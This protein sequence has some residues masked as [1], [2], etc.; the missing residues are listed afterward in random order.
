[1]SSSPPRAEAQVLRR[2]RLR[3]ALWSGSTTLIV[4]L[5]LG[6]IVYAFVAQQLARDSEEQLRARATLIAELKDPTI[7]PA[8]AS[9]LGLVAAAEKAGVLFGGPL[10]GTI[11]ITAEMPD[12]AANDLSRKTGASDKTGLQ[13]AGTPTAVELAAKQPS[14][15]LKKRI[16]DAAVDSGSTDG[17]DL[18]LKDIDGVPTRILSVDAG[19]PE[20]P[21]VVHVIADRTIELRTLSNLAL[22]MLI[23]GFLVVVAATAAGW[24]YSGRALVPIR[25]SLRRQREFAADASHELRTPL[26]VLR[27]ELELL[28]RHPGEPA[29]PELLAD[30]TAETERMARLVDELLL[31]ARTDADQAPLDRRPTDLAEAAFDAAEALTGEA[32]QRSVR[33]EVD[34]SPAPLSGDPDRLRQLAAI[35]VD[36]AIKHGRAGGHVWVR[37]R[38]DEADARLEVADDGAGIA[39]EDRERIFLRFWRGCD[40]RAPGSGLGLPIARWIVD[41]HDGR[42]HVAERP[43][44]GT[45]IVV[46]LP[47]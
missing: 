12:S 6:V 34:A 11:A 42:I 35:L 3:L 30:A 19:T 23:G 21:F 18:T 27:N 24:V 20:E 9:T 14:L 37:V 44:G 15:T 40:T 29:D 16:A 28:A 39:P 26:T 33:V 31:L 2:T 46:T 43:E 47:R 4:L 1:M 38:S 45:R 8:D 25:A 5:I 7:E 13:R 22:A 32:E 17:S 36:N 10:S 41:A